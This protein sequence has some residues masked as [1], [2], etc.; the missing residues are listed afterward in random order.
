MAYLIIPSNVL[1]TVNTYIGVRCDSYKSIFA[2]K[3]IVMSRIS[4][5]RNVHDITISSK[6]WI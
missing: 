1:L 5:N 3:V 4:C 2:S 6:N